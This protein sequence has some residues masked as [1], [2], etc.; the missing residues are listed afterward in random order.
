LVARNKNSHI[1]IASG[2]CVSG[3]VLHCTSSIQIC[4]NIT[5]DANVKIFD[6]EFHPIHYLELRHNAIRHNIKIK[7]VVIEEGVWIG[8]HVIILIVVTIGKGAI[9]GAGSVLTQNILP[10]TIW[11]HNPAKFV[12]DI[13]HQL[14]NLTNN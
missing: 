12:H 6:H 8:G 2:K 1:F 10:F 5:I 7:P 13:K 9:I 11:A 4:R 14:L 3:L